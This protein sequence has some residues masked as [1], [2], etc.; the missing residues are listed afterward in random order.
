M[1]HGCCDLNR[2]WWL[3]FEWWSLPRL[4]ISMARSC[5]E[6][7]PKNPVGDE[8]NWSSWHVFAML[9]SHRSGSLCYSSQQNSQSYFFMLPRWEYLAQ[10]N[11]KPHL[12]VHF[13]RMTLHRSRPALSVGCPECTGCSVSRRSMILARD[14]RRTTLLGPASDAMS[15]V[16]S[17]S[18]DAEQNISV[19]RIIEL[20]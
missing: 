19:S 11:G 8:V 10:F 15:S 18:G 13:L 1:W 4:S 7:C 16:R 5:H 3:S 6:S 14:A 17:A 2:G 12:Y 9:R 20:L